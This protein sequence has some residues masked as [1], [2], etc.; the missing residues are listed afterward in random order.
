MGA[1]VG[2][3]NMPRSN[4]STVGR[5]NLQVKLLREIQLFKNRSTSI[6]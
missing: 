3:Q 2:G 4:D 1:S 5:Y 6:R